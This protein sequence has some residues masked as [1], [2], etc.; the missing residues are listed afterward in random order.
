[1]G[2][3]S[4]SVAVVGAGSM[5]REH[6]KAFSALPGVKVNGIFSRTRTRAEVLAKEFILD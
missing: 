4:V 6:I 2:N 3:K 1:M 5:A